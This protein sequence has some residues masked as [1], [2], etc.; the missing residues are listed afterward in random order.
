MSMIDNCYTYFRMTNQ[1]LVPT[2]LGF[3]GTKRCLQYLASH[4]HKTIFYPSNS[5]D[6]SNVIKLT[7]SGNQVED[8][9]THNCLECHQYADHYIILNIIRSVSGII[10]TI[11][12][13]SVFWKVHIK[14]DMA[15]DPNDREIRCM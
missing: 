6:V 7:W 5:Y 1:T 2:I 11:L 3:Q 9:T 12:G 13:V 10:H 8:Y 14:P 15:S 4:P